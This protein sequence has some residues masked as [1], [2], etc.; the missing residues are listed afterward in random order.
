MENTITRKIQEQTGL[1]LTGKIG[2]KIMVR[3]RA[4]MGKR[5]IV[6]EVELVKINPGSVMVMLFNGDVI[7]R[8]LK[9]IDE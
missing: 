9:D 5:E 8:K 3:R 6:E 7:K 4:D 1:N 2:E